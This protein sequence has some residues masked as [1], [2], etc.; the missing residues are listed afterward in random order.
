MAITG[1]VRRRRIA[2][3]ADAYIS[4]AT[5]NVPVLVK[6]NSTSHTDL[7]A[8]GDDKDSVWFS[9]DAGGQTTLYH[10]GV[11]F[12]S[13]NAIFYVKVDLSSTADTVIYLWY[14]LPAVTGTEGKTSVWTNGFRIFHFEGNANDSS[15][16]AANGSSSGTTFGTDY[17]NGQGGQ[18]A[19][20]DGNDYISL[21]TLNFPASFTMMA[22]VKNS[23]T[24]AQTVI[25][26]ND[27]STTVSYLRNPE[28]ATNGKGGYAD[29]KGGSCGATT[30]T[31]DNTWRLMT[32]VGNGTTGRYLY[33]NQTLE[34]SDTS[35][36]SAINFTATNSYI[37]K[38]LW[39][40]T[41]YYYNTGYLDEVWVF[42]DAKSADFIKAVY[43][44]IINYS[45]FITIDGAVQIGSSPKQVYPVWE[46][47]SGTAYED[48]VEFTVNVT[49]SATATLTDVETVS[50]T[51]N[52][53]FSQSSGYLE[54]FSKRIELAIDSS[55]VDG[56]LTNF[57]ILIKLSS[58]SG[59]SDKDLTAIFT[60]LGANSKKIAVTTSNNTQCYVEIERWD[61]ANNLAI[62][63]AKIPSIDDEADT[64]LYLYYD[65]S[66]SDNSTYVGDTDSEVAEN[67]WDAN[68]KAV[69]HLNEIIEET[70]IRDSTSNDADFDTVTLNSVERIGDVKIGKGYNGSQMASNTNMIISSSNPAVLGLTWTF[71]FWFKVPVTQISLA[72]C[73]LYDDTNTCYFNLQSGGSEGGQTG[74][75]NNYSLSYSTYNFT[76][77]PH[78]VVVRRNG[79]G[80]V[81]SMSVDGTP[82]NMTGEL[83]D[84]TPTIKY[85]SASGQYQK[86]DLD[87]V[88]IS[89]VVRSDD[90]AK[91]DYYSQDDNLIT[92]GDFE[93]LLQSISVKFILTHEATETVTFAA[94]A[95]KTDV[96]VIEFTVNVS[97]EVIDLDE[98]VPFTA[99]YSFT[100]E[101]ILSQ[102]Q[103]IEFTETATFEAVSGKVDVEVIEFT[104]NVSSELTLSQA[105]NVSVVP[106][107][108]NVAATV[109]EVATYVSTVEFTANATFAAIKEV[110]DVELVEFGVT[111]TA[112]V[113]PTQLSSLIEFTETATFAAAKTT[114]DVEVIEFAAN[115]SM[116]VFE[117]SGT[118]DLV[119]FAVNPSFEVIAVFEHVKTVEFSGIYG[120]ITP[121]LALNLTPIE[122]Q[123][124][125]SFKVMDVELIKFSATVTFEA[126]KTI[127]DIEVIEFSAVFTPSVT[128]MDEILNFTVTATPSVIAVL[129]DI[130]LIEFAA[131][132]TFEASKPLIDVEV[133]EFSA[134]FTPEIETY[135]AE[136]IEFTVTATPKKI[137]NF[138]SAY[139]DWDYRKTKEIV[140]SNQ[141]LSNYPIP[142]TLYYGSG[143]DTD[144]KI[145]LNSHCKTD[146][147]DI[148]FD[149]DG[150]PL[151]YWIE[152]KVDSNYAIIWIKIPTLAV[153]GATIY[154]YYGNSSATSESSGT[155]VFMAYHD[156]AAD[157]YT[158]TPNIDPSGNFVY[159]C[160]FQYNLQNGNY[161]NFGLK[162]ADDSDQLKFYTLNYRSSPTPY[163]YCYASNLNNG[164][165]VSTT[166]YTTVSHNVH[167]YE[168]F[169][170]KISN[171]VE[172]KYKDLSNGN[173]TTVGTLSTY[174]PDT[175]LGLFFTD[176]SDYASNYIRWAYVKEYITVEPYYRASG[177][178]ENNNVLTEED[179]IDLLWSLATL[180]IFIDVSTAIDPLTYISV[181][182]F[183]ALVTF[184]TY[185]PI[186]DI[187]LIE[188]G[189]TANFSTPYAKVYIDIDNFKVTALNIGKSISDATWN[190]EISIDGLTSPSYFKHLAVELP[191]HLSVSRTI[192]VGFIPHGTKDIVTAANKSKVTAYDYSWYL[193]VQF[194]PDSMLITDDEPSDIIY[195]FLGGLAWENTTGITPYVLTPV[196]NW[197]SIQKTFMWDS[198]TTK[199]KAIQ[200]IC[201]YIGYIFLVKWNKV[202]T[203]YY[204]VAYFIPKADIDTYLNLPSA[205][206]FTSGSTDKQ[207]V[208]GIKIEDNQIELINYVKV[209]GIDTETGS[210]F[211]TTVMEDSVYYDDTPAIEY[212]YEST[213]LNNQDLVDAK[214]LE[215]YNLLSTAAKTYT[216]T[217]LN[218]TDL[219]LYQKL[220]FVGFSEIDSNW[221]RIISINFVNSATETLVTVKLASDDDF[222]NKDN[223]NRNVS[224]FTDNIVKIVDSKIYDI[225]TISVGTVTNVSGSTATVLLEDGSGSV[226]ARLLN[227]T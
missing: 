221:Y 72:I 76:G 78:F 213:D 163:R 135:Q 189:Y 57:P 129:T 44:N 219:E 159:R 139:G 92:Y 136:L 105:T 121:S 89:N 164:G 120:L 170:T 53:L 90:W 184:A 81:A 74:W 161:H 133:I 151:S 30:T 18:G 203:L 43:N 4:G 106:F 215:L 101:A 55:K 119:E 45:T 178:E 150:T 1:Q 38:E 186:I 71:S 222:T 152:E 56:D 31:S 54:G 21:G 179:N 28:N 99:N 14:G 13:T 212:Y 123:E 181:I 226:T 110:T 96:E 91:A 29:N 217:F 122:F 195:D 108:A 52:I 176:R 154:V 3:N 124:V 16:N 142:L 114:I 155:D 80:A 224:D 51:S 79:S 34:A 112:T 146:F 95:A 127:T 158:D 20:F 190:C 196:S 33:V 140:G 94:T 149:L 77:N 194:V 134:T 225:P 175:T 220:K 66:A 182:N 48:T 126:A 117:G 200:E 9:S 167:N 36:L 128:E 145:Y 185:H 41:N 188:F 144:N 148:R 7:F 59:I 73:L 46:V 87:E 88:R 75:N 191:D 60:E 12:D 165:G 32:A 100:V 137:I 162:N 187:E 180:E 113:L 103:T 202:G 177:N 65:S 209:R 131:T 201:E 8:T 138:P 23:G 70:P 61:N 141:E 143:T 183:T 10:E 69:Y 107:T 169:F 22:W 35:E 102:T 19:Y 68:F 42:S 166:P 153:T 206:T 11:V 198:K 27:N 26:F 227:Q 15:S 173:V 193:S 63:W 85:L 216:V 160:K 83:N 115:V 157:P 5:S 156:Y 40:G 172:Y 208:D 223:V 168:F 174:I 25:D 125:A 6:F 204:P 50:F 111:A 2:I 218:R 192:F 64:T 197:N 58:S 39:Q 214:A 98:V 199:L 37:G 62:L 130:E 49:P 17:D 24:S 93:I 171:S 47:Q 207:I 132:A 82:I 86:F 118:Q 109:E 104:V 147:S 205:I 84:T 67:V 97:S 211:T 210:Y 116:D